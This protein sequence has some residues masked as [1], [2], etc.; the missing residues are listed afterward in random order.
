MDGNV[1]AGYSSST[2]HELQTNFLMTQSSACNFTNWMQTMP[3][4]VVLRGH[5]AIN[6]PKKEQRIRRPMN[7]FMVW[8]KTARKLLADENPDVHN[9][10]LS[11]ML[12][13]KWKNLPT[14]EKKLYIDEAERIRQEH[15]KQY[16]DYKYRPRRRK[17]SKKSNNNL[18]S[19]IQQDRFDRSS[20]CSPQYRRFP[21]SNSFSFDNF[22]K[23]QS[24][25]DCRRLTSSA[26]LNTRLSVSPESNPPSSP[27][28][29]MHDNNTY[30][31]EHSNNMRPYNFHQTTVS[32]ENCRL[33][34]HSV[35]GFVSKIPGQVKKEIDLNANY[36][37]SIGRTT[38]FQGYSLQYPP[39]YS[40]ITMQGSSYNTKV[41]QSGSYEPEVDIDVSDI[42]PEDM[43]IYINP[44][45]RHHEDSSQFNQ[46]AK[47]HSHSMHASKESVNGFQMP[48]EH[49]I[50]TVECNVPA[51][52]QEIEHCRD[53]PSVCYEFDAQ[54][55]INALTH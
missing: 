18:N 24:E 43:D 37:D 48:N 16:P 41:D 25:N 46:T 39:Q 52:M 5:G 12:G 34:E 1:I 15:M 23:A 49:K 6:V 13:N 7:A 27:E 47:E 40:T 55:I 28:E 17:P 35:S 54:P 53:I 8:A 11:K 50:P 19:P 9:A 10:E 31:F 26:P 44:N 38:K 33:S 36:C 51:V 3:Y 29:A 30:Y 20:S 45:S 21:R 32:L 42:S 22:T 2:P 4:P 14:E